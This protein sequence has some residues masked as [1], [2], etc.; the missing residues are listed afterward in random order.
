[1]DLQYQPRRRKPK[2]EEHT[3]TATATATAMTMTATT[4]TT[5]PPAPQLGHRA[6]PG[7]LEAV[8]GNPDCAYGRLYPSNPSKPSYE[9]VVSSAYGPEL[10]HRGPYE[11]TK[12]TLDQ[13]GLSHGKRSISRETSAADE[14]Q[15]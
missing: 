11:M 9:R 3:A 2:V 5:P 10:A 4:T 13:H 14:L 6:I 8:V 15:A 1:L 7:S 12:F